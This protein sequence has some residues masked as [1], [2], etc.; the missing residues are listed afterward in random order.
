[1]LI[2]DIHKDMDVANLVYQIL[3]T[4]RTQATARVRT[5]LAGIWHDVGDSNH[6]VWSLLCCPCVSLVL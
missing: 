3:T 6:L 5:S 1:M 4:D 2:P